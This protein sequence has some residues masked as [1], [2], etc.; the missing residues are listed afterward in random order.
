RTRMI[1]LK[2]AVGARPGS[3]LMEFLVE[4]VTLC[5]TGG[6]I[7]ILIVLLLSLVMNYGFDFPI[8]LSSKNFLIGVGISG[9]VGVLA[10][11]IPARSAARL[12]PVVA[13]RSH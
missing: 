11:Y 8:T 9:V 2:K 13:I 7:G 10:G 6:L 3:I 1:G 5:L 4:A 12:D